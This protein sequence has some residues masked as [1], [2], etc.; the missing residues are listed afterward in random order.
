MCGHR[1]RAEKDGLRGNA[2][3]LT[4]LTTELS[5]G[6]CARSPPCSWPAWLL[7]VKADSGQLLV[8]SGGLRASLVTDI[9]G[10]SATVQREARAG[11]SAGGAGSPLAAARARA[12]LCGSCL[13]ADA[14]GGVRSI[15]LGDENWSVLRLCFPC[16]S[17]A[18]PAASVRCQ[19]FLVTGGVFMVH[20]LSEKKPLV[21]SW[22]LC[23]CKS[24]SFFN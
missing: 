4:T 9:E 13:R 17:G 12:C 15:R 5:E 22:F 7:L 24:D 10:S 3:V 18:S 11:A 8:R 23:L 16:C 19:L 1:E 21:R 6:V 14:V 20:R 2:T